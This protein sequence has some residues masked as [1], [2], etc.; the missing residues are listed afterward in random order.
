MRF[1]EDGWYVI[2]VYGRNDSIW[3]WSPQ[4]I[5]HQYLHPPMKMLTMMVTHTHWWS[6]ISN[7]VMVIIHVDHH[8]IEWWLLVREVQADRSDDRIIRWWWWWWWGR[9]WW[10]WC[11]WRWWWWWW[12]AGEG[13]SGRQGG[14]AAV[15]DDAGPIVR[16]NNNNNNQNNNEW[17]K[18]HCKILPC[19]GGGHPG[20][21]EHDH[22]CFGDDHDMIY[23][24]DDR[25]MWHWYNDHYDD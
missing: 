22:S 16:S 10:G 8:Q 20:D 23:G 15:G 3:W 9:R 18:T 13:G 5:A 25:N 11:W 12:L 4:M 21:C 17:C 2:G 6:H 1:S 19:E 24:D 7:V 14:G